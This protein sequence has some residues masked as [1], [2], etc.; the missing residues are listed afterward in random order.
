MS[1]VMLGIFAGIFTTIIMCNFAHAVDAS[2]KEHSHPY[3]HDHHHKSNSPLTENDHKDKGDGHDHD[4]GKG[5][6]ID[7]TFTF[8][9]SLQC[10][11]T[12]NL[13]LNSKVIS[14]ALSLPTFINP[15]VLKNLFKGM[16]DFIEPPPKISDIQV[17]IQSFQI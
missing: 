8:F 3:G 4:S 9:S 1:V 15:L 13:K 11:Y 14:I 16:R 10:D 17:F 12:P 7:F 5:C 2:G 6:C